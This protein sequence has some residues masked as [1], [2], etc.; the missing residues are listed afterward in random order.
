[1]EKLEK[2]ITTEKE[3]KETLKT[4]EKTPTPKE[5]S[6][7]KN[8]QSNSKEKKKIDQKDI[9]NFFDKE[10]TSEKKPDDNKTISEDMQLKKYKNPNKS[11]KKVII[12]LIILFAILVSIVST[13]FGISTSCTDKIVAGVSINNVDVS[14]LTKSEA[15]SKLTT[16]LSGDFDKEIILAHGDYQTKLNPTSLNATYDLQ[17]SV[18]CA[19]DIG[20]AE[21]NI[22]SNNFKVLGALIM[23]T[24]ITPSINYDSTLL[25]EKID[26]INGELPDRV[27]NSNYTIEG[28]KLIISSGCDGYKI[29]EDEFINLVNSSLS[30]NNLKIEIPV[31]KYHTDDVDIDKIYNEV[32]KKPVDATFNSNPYEIHKEE[33]GLD[34]DISLDEARAMV[35]D[36]QDTYTIPL[37]TLKPSVTLQSLPLEAFPDQLSTY[38]TTYA[39]SNYNRSTNISLAARAVNG[40]VL[41][42]GETFSYNNTL[43]QR[44]AA[45]GYKEAGAYVNGQVSSEVGGGICQVSSTLYNAALLCNLEIV[46]RTNHTFQ[47]SY[48][49]AGQD[50]TV[51]WQSPD[52]KFKNNRQYPIKISA[53]AGSGRITFIIYGLTSPDDY[54][55]KIQSS[56]TDTIPFSTQYVNDDSLPV[57]T[58]KVTQAGSNGCKSVTYKILYKDGNEVSRTLINSDTYKPHNQI[59]AKG[60]KIVQEEEQISANI[61][62]DSVEIT[63]IT[64]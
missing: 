63:N 62:N 9:D 16:Q 48:V 49:P 6:E 17:K 58:T 27:I 34:F 42:P 40:I 51:S 25:K 45:K 54:E 22:F 44:T 55:V 39:S 59:V 2:K 4:E 47:S 31:E 19:Y 3:S 8:S 23:K 46:D 57:G 14:N 30:E 56:I 38:T 33:N 43:G 64:E 10:K 36:R 26:S 29:Q 41:M 37:K 28:S 13:A 21:N 12:L 53:S 52:F 15:L 61:S 5:I 18:D 7:Q 35:A 50:A 24:D 32:Y 20:R 11:R 60:T 1:M